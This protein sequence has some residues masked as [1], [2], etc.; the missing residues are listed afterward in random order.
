MTYLRNTTGIYAQ[1][2]SSSDVATVLR[3]H[4][5]AIS[6]HQYY[7]RIAVRIRFNVFFNVCYPLVSAIVDERTSA[8]FDLMGNRLL[9]TYTQSFSSQW[10][11]GREMI[12]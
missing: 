3:L 9:R 12:I 1:G 8:A 4:A 10:V 2:T 5:K 7:F 6:D 11:A